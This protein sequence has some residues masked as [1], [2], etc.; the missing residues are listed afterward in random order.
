MLIVRDFVV[1]RYRQNDCIHGFHESKA[2]CNSI[3]LADD[4]MY[5]RALAENEKNV[6]L[7]TVYNVVVN[8]TEWLALVPTM[9]IYVLHGLYYST[10]SCQNKCK[11][12]LVKCIRNMHI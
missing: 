6:Q 3:S 5:A 11:Q 8:V 10:S 1:M 4:Y 7:P 12:T 9:S 2:A